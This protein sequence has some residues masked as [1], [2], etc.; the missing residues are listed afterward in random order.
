[1][2]ALFRDL[3]SATRMKFISQRFPSSVIKE[4]FLVSL[5]TMPPPPSSSERSLI[6]SRMSHVTIGLEAGRLI[7]PNDFAKT[8]PLP[9]NK[10]WR[11]YSPRENCSVSF[12]K[13]KKKK[14][15]KTRGNDFAWRFLSNHSGQVPPLAFICN[16]RLERKASGHN[17]HPWSRHRISHTHT[18]KCA[19]RCPKCSSIVVEDEF[20]AVIAVVKPRCSDFYCSFGVS[21]RKK[22]KEKNEPHG[23]ILTARSRNSLRL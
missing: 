20:R 1:M 12:K 16:S 3:T 10:I 6:H 4:H 21:S 15:I 11:K 5:E 23:H 17:G 7:I 14:N 9:A 22:K 18:H 19:T 13:K 2:Y 8:P